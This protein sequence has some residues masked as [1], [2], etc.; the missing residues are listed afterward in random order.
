MVVETPIVLKNPSMSVIDFVCCS[1]RAH[2]LRLL[3]CLRQIE[4]QP[5]LGEAYIDLCGESRDRRSQG[6]SP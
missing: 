1:R 5:R 6:A 2:D 3:N 4:C